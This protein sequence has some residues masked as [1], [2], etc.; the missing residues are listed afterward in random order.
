MD[1]GVSQSLNRTCN[2][3][4]LLIKLLVHAL[5][6]HRASIFSL[7]FDF[8]AAIPHRKGHVDKLRIPS[9]L[10][11]APGRQILWLTS[12]GAGC[13]GPHPS[14]HLQAGIQATLWRLLLSYH[15]PSCNGAAAKSLAE[16]SGGLWQAKCWVAPAPC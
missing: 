1:Q 11:F 15:P 3:K 5:A 6:L 12:L 9:R 16:H 14:Q 13:R 2:D 4:G 8:S 7:V 10:G